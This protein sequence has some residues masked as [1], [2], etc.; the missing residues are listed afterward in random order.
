MK[1]KLSNPIVQ[2]SEWLHE[3]R[4]ALFSGG[5]KDV[6][7]GDCIGCC[8]SYYNIHISPEEKDVLARIPKKF[9][10][11]A[12]DRRD[13]SIVLGYFDDGAC[14]MLVEGKC[15]TYDC[16]PKTCQRYDCRVAAAAGVIIDGD[17]K[18]LINQS[19]QSWQFEYPTEQDQIEHEAV[20]KAAI[21]LKENQDCFPKE[22]RITENMQ[23]AIASITI[24]KVFL[25][26]GKGDKKSSTISNEDIAKAI[27]AERR[28]YTIPK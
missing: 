3:T 19:I 6:P 2:F 14:P 18:V 15:T 1:A 26:G 12:P 22:Y 9:W 21:F 20:I 13:G 24:Y 25:P 23:L 5:A 16:R 17:K 28:L 10:N 4:E 8:T 27:I 11:P 7:C